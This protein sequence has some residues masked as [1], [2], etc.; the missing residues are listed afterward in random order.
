MNDVL[1][2]IVAF[3]IV[4]GINV[5][6]HEFGHYIAARLTGV[7][8]ETF[9]F[10]FGKRLFGKKVG[11]TDFRLS[12][13]PLGG[14]VKM[15][16]EDEYDPHDLKPY[17]FHAKNRGQ[18]I[19]ILIM[20]PMMNMVLAFLIYTIINITG[21]EVEAYK[22][23]LPVIGYV[24]KGSSAEKAGIRKGDLIRTFDGRTI[25]D[26]K[27]LEMAVASNPNQ[28]IPVEFEREGKLQKMVTM[29]IGTNPS[30]YVGDAGISWGFET[31]I[32]AV[33]MDSPAFK[34]GVK[35]DDFIRAIDGKPVNILETFDIISKS[36]DKPLQFTIERDDKPFDVTI[37]PKK[38]N[39]L[40]S[41]ASPGNL[42]EANRLLEETRKKFPGFI[43]NIYKNE[44]KFKIRSNEIDT[45]SLTDL[46][47]LLAVKEK[48][49]IGAELLLYSP[50]IKTYY[51]FFAAMG[52]SVTEMVMM[53]EMTFSN[54]RK[55]IV[56]KLSPKGLSGPLDIAKFSGEAMKLG[57]SRFI[58]LIAYISLQLG[59]INL[60]PIP[61]LDGG[62]L[63]TF[64]IEAIIRR[65]FSPKVKNIVI[66]IGFFLLIALMVFVILN[67]ISKRVPLPFFN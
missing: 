14:Y 46:Q 38:V 19:F 47:G 53:I 9:S 40:E 50:T 66:N 3:V 10:G 4:L 37:I 25:K 56:G 39:Y 8:V 2:S 26:W 6:V 28:K 32:K 51:G 67:D 17:E 13:I 30:Y 16:G 43:F 55:M 33:S 27:E 15:S 60:F 65:D 5:L 1:I 31:K 12:L 35:A 58:W 49:Q 52:K 62:H 45:S 61:A 54:L 18:K 36:P 22:S 63:L 20:G 11:E 59:I 48:G 24:E 7:R 41:T 57:F 44:E 42:K 64:T 23:S 29:D 34:A 21:V